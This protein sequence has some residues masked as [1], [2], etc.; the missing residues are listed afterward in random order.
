MRRIGGLAAKRGRG[1][2]QQGFQFRPHIEAFARRVPA[3]AGQGG[4]SGTGGSLAVTGADTGWM[5]ASLLAALA[6][7]G[8]GVIARRRAVRQSD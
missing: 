3:G 6:L 5:G 4:T 8:L 7:L 2:A 1:R